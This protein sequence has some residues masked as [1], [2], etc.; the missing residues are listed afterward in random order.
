MNMSQLGLAPAVFVYC[1]S[2]LCIITPALA[3]RA[4]AGGK[5]SDGAE[6][7]SVTQL[8]NN[9]TTNFAT[10]TTTKYILA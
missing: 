10:I 8:L 4:G 9:T 1:I 7:H 6:A 2:A 3:I 5:E